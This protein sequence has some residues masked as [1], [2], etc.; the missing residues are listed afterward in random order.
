MTE[1]CIDPHLLEEW[2]H[3]EGSCFIRNDWHD[4]LPESWV[5]HQIAHQLCEG[6]RGAH[7]NA[8]PRRK[9]L[10]NGRL[11]RSPDRRVDDARWERSAE[12]GAALCDVLR[13]WA[14]WSW[15]VVRSFRDL[16]IRDRKVEP[17]S[18]G[19]QL[20]LGQLLRLVRRVRCFYGWAQRPALH[21]LREDH[22][23]GTLMCHGG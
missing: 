2:I 11:W 21:R 7:R 22:R 17:V 13:L 6:H 10:I 8:T 14:R 4:E 20:R 5:T 19:A 9:L 16:L 18:E 3:A 15:V 1:R 12:G 23:W